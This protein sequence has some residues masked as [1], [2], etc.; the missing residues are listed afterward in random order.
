MQVIPVS[1][2]ARVSDQK[3]QAYA[4]GA[5]LAKRTARPVSA[6]VGAKAHAS[7]TLA[8]Y[9]APGQFG[10]FPCYGNFSAKV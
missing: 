9:G 7:A 6:E 4:S 3:R 8:L 1:P 10:A 2:I 5:T